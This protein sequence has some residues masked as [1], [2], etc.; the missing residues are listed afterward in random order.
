[1]DRRTLRRVSGVIASKS[2]SVGALVASVALIAIPACGGSSAKPGG[3]VPA[4][5]P[6]SDAG[7]ATVTSASGASGGSSS[8]SS[9]GG[10]SATSAPGER[11]FAKTSAEATSMIDDVIDQRHKELG[12]CVQ[13][14]QTRLKDPHAA[15]AVDVGIDQEGM[16]IGVKTPKGHKVDATLNQC[17]LVALKGAPFPR[18]N[19]GVI[20][21]H[22]TFSDKIVY[23]E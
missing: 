20:T 7:A 17:V 11:A 8:A 23:T 15:I 3:D 10:A 22:K 12:A 19:A 16:L 14:A 5:E 1:M 13:A 9:D 21:V 4:S 18:S 2:S 6:A